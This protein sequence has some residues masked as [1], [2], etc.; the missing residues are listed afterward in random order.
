MWLLGPVAAQ[1]GEGH[2]A[3]VPIGASRVDAGVVRP[4]GDPRRGCAR[5][6][7]RDVGTRVVR[8]RLAVE[9]APWVSRVRRLAS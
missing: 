5:A 1:V 3:D 7:S 4:V 9:T 2:R 6:R 8:P